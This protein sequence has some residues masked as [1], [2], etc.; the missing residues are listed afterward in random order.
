MFLILWLCFFF[1]QAEDGIRD[2]LVTGVQTCALPISATAAVTGSSQAWIAVTAAVAVAGMIAAGVRMA[3]ARRANPLLDVTG[4]LLTLAAAT[5]VGT[6]VPALLIKAG[7]AW[8]AW[9]LQ[10]S[11]SGQFGQR[12]ARL[13]VLGNSAAPAGGPLL[14]AVPLG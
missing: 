14:R 13:L 1:F 10:V 2:D 11:S 9:V 12:L 7:D 4:G 5:T 3:I 6:V 8:S